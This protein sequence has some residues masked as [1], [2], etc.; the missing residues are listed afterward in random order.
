VASGS[1]NFPSLS[2]SSQLTLIAGLLLIGI[3]GIQ[4][5]QN[6]NE[7]IICCKPPKHSSPIEAI[8]LKAI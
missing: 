3:V 1:K 8:S 7:G 6:I 4:A 5:M 2:E